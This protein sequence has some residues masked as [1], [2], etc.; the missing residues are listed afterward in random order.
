MLGQTR[1]NAGK[2]SEVLRI[3]RQ[4]FHRLGK[5]ADKFGGFLVAAVPANRGALNLQQFRSLAEDARHLAI[6]HDD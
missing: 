3:A 6:F 2:G 4:F 1:A 5:A